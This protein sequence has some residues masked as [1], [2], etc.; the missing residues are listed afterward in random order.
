MGKVS[1][2]QPVKFFLG[3]LTSRPDLA[4][5][6]EER[7][8]LAFGEVDLRSDSFPFNSTD[9]Y[10]KEMGK[11]I[12]RRFFSLSD[13]RP[14]ELLAEMKLKTN[15]LETLFAQ[16]VSAVRRPVNLDPGY[17]EQSKIVLASTK[18][19]YHRILLADGIYA[20]VT[21]HYEKGGWQPFP[22]TFP[23]F[24][25]GRYNEFFTRLREV[26]RSQLRNRCRLR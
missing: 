10:E 8:S 16:A 18:N 11:P 23:D 19:F 6:I 2:P 4:A 13:L 26:Y 14:A 25:G 1:S 20:E 21:M 7:I 15:E 12:T 24:R 22:W 9:Y 3:L 5:E 17:I